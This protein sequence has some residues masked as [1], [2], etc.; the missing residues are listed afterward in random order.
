MGA[1]LCAK[2]KIGLWTASPALLDPV[3][4]EA[5]G[6]LMP[7]GQ[8]GTV[9]TPEPRLLTVQVWDKGLVKATDKAIRDAGRVLIIATGSGK[10][11]AV[12]LAERGEVPSGMIPG[13][14]WLI[15]RAAAGQ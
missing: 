9:S 4:V 6:N 15:D 11:D 2:V 7:I 5:Y 1:A 14:R 13:A 3:K 12:A 8:V 10:A